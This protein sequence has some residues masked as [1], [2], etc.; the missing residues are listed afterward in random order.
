MYVYYYRT[1]EKAVSGGGSE[2][3]N[4]V[5]GGKNKKRRSASASVY[6][7]KWP[8]TVTVKENSAHWQELP[9]AK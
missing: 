5:M 2:G 4:E 1:Y 3:K 6:P 9:L 7:F 8:H